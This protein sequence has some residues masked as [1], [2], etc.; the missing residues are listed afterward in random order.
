MNAISMR[1]GTRRST[2]ATTQSGWV[3]QCL[4]DLGHEVEIVEI[5]TFG[6]TSTAP[7]SS[8]GGTG[9][10]VTAIRKALLDG[11]IDV[12][13]HSLKDLPVAPEPGLRIAAIPVREDPRDALVAR[14]GLALGELPAG[15]VVGTG[16]PRRAAQLTALGLDVSVM[17]IRGNVDTRI[18]LVH[19]GSCDAVL[20]ARAGL[21]R[22]GRLDEVTESLDPQQMLPAPGQG[23]LAVECRE[24][25]PGVIEALS[26]LDDPDT[27]AAVSA[28]R[29]LLAALEAGCT[30]PVGALATVAEGENGAELHLLAFAGSKDASIALRRSATGP[31]EEP[32]RLGRDLAAVLLADGADKIAGLRAAQPSGGPSPTGQPDARG[33]DASLGAP[34]SR[35]D[36]SRPDQTATERVL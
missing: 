33:P 22:L 23:A 3:A 10:F 4:R 15:S 31:L 12:A 18:S 27:R 9:V 29:A 25:R 35:P 26:A 24:D 17:D 19:K 36:S 1:L 8:I 14:D 16:S 20:L 32:E 34:A 13:V 2:L 11:E 21:A 6:D 28:E 7:L 30:A 5:T